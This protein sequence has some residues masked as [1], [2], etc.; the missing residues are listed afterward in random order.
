MEVR[1]ER[2][3]QSGSGVGECSTPPGD[4]MARGS[5]GVDGVGGSE[6]TGWRC[7]EDL[8]G[9]LGRSCGWP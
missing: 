7:E 9:L 8:A 1:W 4:D 3:P 2:I 5:R 6:G